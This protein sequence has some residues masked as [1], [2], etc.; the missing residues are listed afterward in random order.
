MMRPKYLA[1]ACLALALAPGLN[2]QAQDD[3]PDTALRGIM[4]QLGEDMQAVTGAISEE[5]W[6]RVVQL[7]PRIGKH[8]EPPV[9]EKMRI[10]GWLGTDARQF[11]AMDGDVGKAAAKLQQ[12]AEQDDGQAVI[13]AF[14]QVQQSCLACHQS[15]RQPFVQQFYGQRP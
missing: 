6:A 13:A 5:D 10:L 4:Q 9:G 15:F 1:T 3:P 8:E 2:V 7:A 14:A 11:R 12:A